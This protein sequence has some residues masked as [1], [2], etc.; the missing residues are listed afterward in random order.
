MKSFNKKFLDEYLKTSLKDRNANSYPFL[1][2][3]AVL[4]QT[5]QKNVL[6]YCKQPQNW[7]SKAYDVDLE[8]EQLLGLLHE[9]YSSSFYSNPDRR[10]KAIDEF[11]NIRERLKGNPNINL[12]F[13][14]IVKFSRRDDPDSY[15]GRY[16]KQFETLVKQEY[17]L[18]NPGKTI[19]CVGPDEDYSGLMSYLFLNDIDIKDLTI[20][21]PFNIYTD[22]KGNKV[23]HTF[24]PGFWFNIKGFD[25]MDV[26]ID[27]ILR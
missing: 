22:F 19:F 10:F 1:L 5:Y 2:D 14:N 11:C 17:E 18:I 21:N 6:F 13:N 15:D 27:F 9:E 12:I 20:D 25:M 4:N 7:L 23:L 8:L 16:Y 26:I 24:H 3:P